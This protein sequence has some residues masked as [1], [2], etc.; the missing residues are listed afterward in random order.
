MSES[1]YYKLKRGR[2]VLWENQSTD[3]VV[4]SY[5]GETL[6]RSDSSGAF[7]ALWNTVPKP[8]KCCPAH[9]GT[10]DWRMLNSES[11][12][13]YQYR[14]GR[15]SWAM[16]VEA[17][18]REATVSGW[19]LNSTLNTSI[20]RGFSWLPQKSS[21]SPTLIFIS[22]LW[23]P[24]ISSWHVAI[25]LGFQVVSFGW[26]LLG[27]A[28]KSRWGLSIPEY[29][30][31]NCLMDLVLTPLGHASVTE[32]WKSKAKKMHSFYVYLSQVYD[33]DKI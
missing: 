27:E 22:K 23:M 3:G 15:R 8:L 9:S 4:P 6:P 26:V 14:A 25:F 30:L 2:D 10:T 11:W 19:G 21:V 31:Q 16:S 1:S 12:V 32:K 24:M 18:L 5:S 33:W 20:G 13:K 29:T 7:P 17:I 28:E